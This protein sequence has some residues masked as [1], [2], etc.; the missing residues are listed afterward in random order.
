[1]FQSPKANII[2]FGY[3]WWAAFPSIQRTGNGTAPKARHL[4]NL[5]QL[6]SWLFH[7]QQVS[8]LTPTLATSAVLS[9]ALWLL[10]QSLGVWEYSTTPASFCSPPGTVM[11]TPNW[12]TLGQTSSWLPSMKGTIVPSNS[13]CSNFLFIYLYFFSGQNKPQVNARNGSRPLATPTYSPLAISQWYVI[14]S[15]HLYTISYLIQPLF[16][17]PWTQEGCWSLCHGSVC[18]KGN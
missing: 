6:S 5:P 16:H 14:P 3:Y 7:W 10:S 4:Q 8:S 13:C 12:L 1:M 9:K 11:E 2:L 17:T 15:I 18:C